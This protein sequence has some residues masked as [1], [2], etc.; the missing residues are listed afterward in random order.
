MLRPRFFPDRRATVF[1][2][3][4]ARNI[5]TPDAR[6]AVVFIM[7]LFWLWL[8][9]TP[10]L[11]PLRG[12]A[13]LYANLFS[14][15]AG[16]PFF[17]VALRAPFFPSVA[18]PFLRKDSCTRD[19][20]VYPAYKLA[21]LRTLL[22]T[23]LLRGRFWAKK[24]AREKQNLPVKILILGVKK[25]FWAWRKLKICPW[26]TITHVKKVK[27]N[28]KTRTWKSHFAREKNE[29]SEKKGFHAHF[30]FHA[31]KKKHWPQV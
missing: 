25:F 30:F 28:R 19:N 1:F 23:R 9:A 16:R 6:C 17:F 18:R 12:L 5:F 14:P 31:Q 13:A 4:F 11:A 8:A 27:R 26:K 24:S 22:F 3:D 2:R 7:A 15:S 29:K 21:A 10:Q 20:P